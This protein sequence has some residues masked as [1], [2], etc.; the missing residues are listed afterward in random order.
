[1]PQSE[2]VDQVVRRR[3]QY[4]KSFPQARISV[5]RASLATFTARPTAWRPRSSSP[6]SFSQVR[7]SVSS[8][9]RNRGCRPGALMA[10]P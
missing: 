9:T 10:R 2:P 1:M 6:R 7:D 8:P 4:L 5:R 3:R